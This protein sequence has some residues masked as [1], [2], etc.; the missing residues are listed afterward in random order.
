MTKKGKKQDGR[1][2]DLTFKW[3]LTTLGPEWEQWQEL[4]AEWMAIQHTGVDHK[5]RALGCFFESYLLEYAPYVTDIGLFFKGYNGHICSTDHA[6]RFQGLTCL[7]SPLHD[8]SPRT[9][10]NVD[11]DDTI[12]DCLT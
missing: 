12:F 3:M 6:N 7:I 9:L 4:A 11:H 5:R 10:G 8:H 2:S 1:A